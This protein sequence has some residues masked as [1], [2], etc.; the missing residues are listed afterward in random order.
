[1]TARYWIA[2][3]L[4]AAA[5]APLAALDRV[6]LKDGRIAEGEIL[7][8]GSDLVSMNLRLPGVSG[9]A[10]RDFEPGL[11]DF[12]DFAPLPGEAEAMSDPDDPANQDNLLKLWREKSVR[13]P[14]PASNAGDIG[15]AYAGALLKRS[16]PELVE[17]A[18]RVFSLVEKDDWDQTRRN[19]ART[20]RLRSLIAL[21][22]VDEAIQEA[23][24][25]ARESEDPALLIEAGLV[26]AQADFE[27]LIRLEREHPRWDQDDELTER[28]EA[29]YHQV[30]DQFLHVPLFH[31]STEERAAEALWQVVLVHQF[32]GET[33]PA[34]DRAR[35]LVQ[36]Y[37]STAEAE[38]ARAM[39]ATVKSPDQ[40]EPAADTP[41][42]SAKP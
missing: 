19:R 15:L 38:K 22:R 39:L 34:L 29:L 20:G 10:K 26:L 4:G 1:M 31:G 6:H 14:W 2:V 27:K 17:R 42:P 24:A 3:C 12:I 23:R 18:Y 37:P 28:R 8:L 33:A 25:V 11:V 36:L 21:Q 35:D 41:P 5:C 40:D 16:E 7:N 9:F 30:L 13:L 32:A